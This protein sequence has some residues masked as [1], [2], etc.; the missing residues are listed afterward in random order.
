MARA[1]FLDLDGTV[2]RGREACPDASESIRRIIALGLPVRYL[3]NNSAARPVPISEK[4]NAMEIPCEPGWVA[5]SGIVA[6]Q[7]L[8]R[9]GIT[10]VGVVGNPGLFESVEE[11]GLEPVPFKNA[12]AVIV[13][14]CHDFTY[15]MLQESS[16]AIRRGVLF[17]A[18]NPDKTYPFE[19]GRL[20]PGA[21]SL[22][23][24]IESASGVAPEVVGKPSPQIVI[25]TAEGIDV[26][27]QDI[28]FAGDRADTDIL[29][30]QNA[31][32]Q[33]WLVL[34]GVTGEPIEGV[35]GSATLAGLA[36][37]LERYS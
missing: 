4:L 16:D 17:M 21:G 14:I 1:V 22:V 6:A 5:S 25:A 20:A 15:R 34:T 24:A 27:V 3:T 23:A 37:H 7:L 26:R 8:S 19:G 36:D 33:P 13:G 29:C 10:R 30:A 18:T 31:G 2:Y 32:C 12:Q 9:R 35:P 11:A 28:V